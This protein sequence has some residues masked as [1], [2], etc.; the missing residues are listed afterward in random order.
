MPNHVRNTVHF[1]CDEE[2]LKE[3]LA[4][5][6]YD[7]DGER[8]QH[9]AGT[10]DFNK[11]IPMPPSLMIECGSST[12]R[13][14]R[15]YREFIDLYTFE[16][17]RDDVDLLNI[18]EENEQFFLTKYEGIAPNDFALGKIAYQNLLQYG[19]STWYQWACNNWGTKWNSYDSEDYQG[20]HDIH[21]ST[22]WSAPHPVLEKLSEMFPDVF[23]THKWADEDMGNNCGERDYADG[24]CLGESY[25]APF[26]KEAYDLA[27]EQWGCEPADD[28]YV[29]SSDGEKY[30]YTEMTEYELIELCGQPALF[31]N[32]RLTGG[33]VPE[34]MYHYDL[35]ES[36]D[37]NGFVSV[38]PSV[39]VNHG[40]SIITNEPIDFDAKGYIALND[41]TSPNFLGD[42]LTLHQFMN[43]DFEQEHGGMKLE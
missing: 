12:D 20:G 33:D 10:L 24:E 6:Q 9:G 18:P 4:A 14:L 22:A 8:L 30:I 38:E 13:G 40:G 29:L 34:G 25:P 26:S 15:A 21:F 37:G 2:R 7:D 1:D 39:L 19:A 32:E 43:G 16:G 41:D 17:T 31:T 3:I 5:I 28:G 36:D 42:S 35:R 11:I 27:F 23:I